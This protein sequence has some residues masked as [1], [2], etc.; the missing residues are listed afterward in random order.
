V[1]RFGPVVERTLKIRSSDYQECFLDLD[2]GKVLSLPAD[3]LVMIPKEGQSR[4]EEALKIIPAWMKKNGVDVFDG[5]QMMVP[6]ELPA[7]DLPGSGSVLLTHLQG[8]MVGEEVGNGAWDEIKPAELEA[9]LAALRQKY[10]NPDR[11]GLWLL[12]DSL[13]HTYLFQTREGGQGILQLLDS[14]TVEHDGIPLRFKMLE[15]GPSAKPVT[16]Q[17]EPNEK[18]SATRFG[19]VIE[20]TVQIHSDHYYDCFLD[21]DRGLIFSLPADLLEKLPKEAPSRF[22]EASK[23]IPEW[24]K[25][26]GIDI[27]ALDGIH[28][29]LTEPSH[30]EF[31]EKSV[32]AISILENRLQGLMFGEKVDAIAWDR[33]MPDQLNERLE[34]LVAR[35][36]KTGDAGVQLL[37]RG[38]EQNVHLLTGEV[39]NTYIFQTREGRKGILQL[40]DPATVDHKGIPIRYKMLE[41]GK[42]T[43]NVPATYGPPP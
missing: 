20:R 38:K 37:A 25:N 8:L 12:P 14:V 34:N 3:L 24:M 9:R 27:A 32:D 28:F 18:K 13:R 30:D 11:A 36:P 26:T 21:L 43:W 7:H 33:M 39:P 1:P 16:P 10:S 6:F 19:S 15:K 42:Q 41:K 40:L 35:Y 4:I 23:I 22:E 2:T 17:E 5:M 31:Q 29:P